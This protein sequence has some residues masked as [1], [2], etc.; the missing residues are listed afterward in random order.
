MT[1]NRLVLLATF[2]LYILIGAWFEERKLLKDFGPAYAEYK[3]RVPMLFPK[4]VNQ[5]SQIENKK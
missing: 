4:I 5:K 2:T 3:T 1:V